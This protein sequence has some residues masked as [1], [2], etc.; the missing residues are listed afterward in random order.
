MR[1]TSTGDWWVFSPG[2]AA[3]VS[4][5]RRGINIRRRRLDG[6]GVAAQNHRREQLKPAVWGR[7]CPTAVGRG[8]G[9]RRRGNG[10]VNACPNHISNG[11]STLP[12][13][14]SPPVAVTR[15]WV[16]SRASSTSGGK[17]W[18]CTVSSAAPTRRV[19][20]ATS[21]TVTIWELWAARL[22]PGRYLDAAAKDSAASPPTLI[23]G[24]YLSLK[25]G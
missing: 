25:A 12:G 2:L 9:E 17:R 1:A 14:V 15:R 23:R 10:H 4:V 5:R 3:G 13:G 19:S 16:I 24:R 18:E 8:T 11:Y 7:F 6:R 20:S 22:S 21:V